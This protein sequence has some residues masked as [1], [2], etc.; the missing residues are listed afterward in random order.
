MSFCV[1]L[2]QLSSLVPFFP[3]EHITCSVVQNSG[4]GDAAGAIAENVRQFGRRVP[5]AEMVARIDAITTKEIQAVRRTERDLASFSL[6]A[7]GWVSPVVALRRRSL[8]VEREGRN[9]EGTPGLRGYT[10]RRHSLAVCNVRV[11]TVRSG[12][13]AS[14]VLTVF[15]FCNRSPNSMLWST[16]AVVYHDRDQSSPSSFRWI[17]HHG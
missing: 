8:Q 5:F 6:P 10:Q 12:S 15:N 9:A 16:E 17:L 3:R 13:R 1:P 7:L 14:S 2:S 11:G 4:C